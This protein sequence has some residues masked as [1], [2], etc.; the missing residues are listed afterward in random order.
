MFA[1]GVPLPPSPYISLIYVCIC[2][3]EAVRGEEGG[4]IH[5]GQHSEMTKKLRL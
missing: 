5:K 3:D 4:R 2:L 1:V